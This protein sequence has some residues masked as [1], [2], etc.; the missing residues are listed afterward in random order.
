MFLTKLSF[1]VL[2]EYVNTTIE[3]INTFGLKIDHDQSDLEL[4]YF[5]IYG[6]PHLIKEFRQ[7]LNGSNKI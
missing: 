1:V 7:F 6:T 5:T 3:D 4:G 2:L